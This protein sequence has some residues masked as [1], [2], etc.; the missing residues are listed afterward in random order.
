[1]RHHEQAGAWEEDADQLNRQ[2]PLLGGKSWS[3]EADHRWSRE[4]AHEHDDG[5]DQG[6]DRRN[7]P[8]HAIRRVS[9][10]ARAARRIHGDERRRQRSLTEHVLKESGNA[11]RGVERGGGVRLEAEVV[12]EDPKTNEAGETAAEDAGGDEKSGPTGAWNHGGHGA[13]TGPY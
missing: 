12:R 11:E 1:G 7:R 5:D 6:Q 9:F 2:I 8:G 3:D 13:V 4:D 10:A